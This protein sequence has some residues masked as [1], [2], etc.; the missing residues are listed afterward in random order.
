MIR[1]QAVV[2][3]GVGAARPFA[4]IEPGWGKLDGLTADADGY[5]WVCPYGGERI[6]RFKFEGRVKRAQPLPARL[7]IQRFFGGPD[8][9]RLFVTTGTR[10]RKPEQDPRA[11]HL[12][13][14]E[15]DVVGFPAN[16]YRD[17]RRL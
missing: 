4:A 14:I 2:E 3:G 9:T 1:I 13:A 15:I 11:G 17:A 12:F 7:I 8:M 16:A 10:G 5:K 6:I